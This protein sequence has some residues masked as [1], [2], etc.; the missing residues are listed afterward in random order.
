LDNLDALLFE[1]NSCW[2]R[3]ISCNTAKI[4]ELQQFWMPEYIVD[5]GTTLKAGGT[6]DSEEFRHFAISKMKLHEVSVQYNW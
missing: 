4:E 3:G 2:L 5:H 6:K 1:R